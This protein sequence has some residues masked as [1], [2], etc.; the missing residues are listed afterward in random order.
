MSKWLKCAFLAA[1]LIGAG[2]FWGTV[3]ERIAQA[4]ELILSPPESILSPPKD[5][6]DLLLQLLLALGAVAVAA[7]LAAALIRPVWVGIVAF[8]LSGVAVLLGWQVTVGSGILVLVYLL[9]GS[10]YVIGVA[11]EL[12][13]RIRFSVRPVSEGQGILLM[14]LALLVCGSLYFG[15]AEHI[16]REGFSIPDAY[17]EIIMGLVEKQIEA[18]LPAEQRQEM[19]AGF[20]E[21]LQRAIDEFIQRTVKPYER[22]IPLALAASLFTPLVTITRLLGWVPGLVLSIL[23]PLL[24]ALRVTKVVSETRE[25]KRLVID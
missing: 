10:F 9:A 20:R 15:Y 8:A 22:F 25:V 2:Y 18:R 24:T 13:E 5:L 4:Y 14:A 7:G 11:R 12:N 23:F 19:V 17:V 3:C 21:E 16:E 1:L 6:L